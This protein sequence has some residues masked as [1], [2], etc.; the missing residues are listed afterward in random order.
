MVG[1]SNAVQGHDRLFGTAI[2]RLGFSVFCCTHDSRS[3]YTDCSDSLGAAVGCLDDARIAESLESDES[4]GTAAAAST[5]VAVVATSAAVQVVAI[6][7]VV[8]KKTTGAHDAQ[9]GDYS[10]AVFGG[11]ASLQDLT[12]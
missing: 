4:C 2:R 9:T 11:A 1:D 3:S 8:G 12:G 10:M 6:G 5:L 7:M